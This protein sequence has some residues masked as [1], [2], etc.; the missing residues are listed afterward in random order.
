[1][2][3]LSR[4]K[5]GFTLVELLVVIAIIGVLAGILLPALSKARE[6]A[7][8]TSCANNLKQV[9]VVLTL[10]GNENRGMYPPSQNQWGAPMLEGDAVYPEYLSDTG[11][12]ACPSDPEYDPK[13]NFRL[14]QKHPDGTPAGRVHPDCI[15]PLSYIY[16]PWMIGSDDEGLA[17][18]TVY[19]WLDS[20]LPLSNPAT[21]FWLD[22]SINLTSFGFS[23]AGNGGSSM[24]YRLSQTVDR[25]L[26]TDINTV[27]TGRE[28]GASLIPVMWDQVSTNIQ[29]Y[30]H[31]PA[32]A[33]VLYLDGHV[34]FGRYGPKAPFPHSPWAAMLCSAIIGEPLPYCP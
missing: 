28:E 1:M 26:I 3:N 5:A 10:Y 6:S 4:S 27:F 14:T 8:R 31:A 22:R 13:R 30:N 32:G 33:N 19:T 15:G 18:F 16:L 24:I 20:V 9:G 29:Q 34:Q 7:R 12:L 11:I 17:L 21:C 23:D 25:F 2:K